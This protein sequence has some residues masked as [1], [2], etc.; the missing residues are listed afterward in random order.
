MITPETAAKWL[1]IAVGAGVA[2]TPVALFFAYR[3]DYIRAG[4]P[5]ATLLAFKLTLSSLRKVK[6][7]RAGDTEHPHKR[8]TDHVTHSH[9]RSEDMGTV[10]RPI[11]ELN[12]PPMPRRKTPDSTHTRR[13][14]DD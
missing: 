1:G 9:V 11:S 10:S 4:H 12:I 2:L 7:F 14:G 5:E 8:A 6:R 3:A 13:T